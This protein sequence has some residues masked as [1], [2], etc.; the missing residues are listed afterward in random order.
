M[1]REFCR[2]FSLKL[3]SGF[4]IS[5]AADDVMGASFPRTRNSDA[6]FLATHWAQ[7]KNRTGFRLRSLPERIKK[8]LH[9]LANGFMRRYR[10]DVSGVLTARAGDIDGD[11]RQDTSVC[12]TPGGLFTHHDYHP[13]QRLVR[14]LGR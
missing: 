12:H 5:L 1:S 8:E 9:P 13:L 3:P 6:D 14:T 4:V 10:F 11:K 7:A 2:C